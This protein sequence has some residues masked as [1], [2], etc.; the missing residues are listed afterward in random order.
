[1]VTALS[2][3]EDVVDVGTFTDGFY[4]VRTDGD[5]VQFGPGAEFE[6]PDVAISDIEHA[7]D[8]GHWIG[9]WNVGAAHIAVDG[10]I[11]I[12]DRTRLGLEGNVH[13]LLP[14]ADA[15]WVATGFGLARVD[16]D[17]G[18]SE[19]ISLVPEFPNTAVQ[20]LAVGA[21]RIWA[22]TTRGLVAIDEDTGALTR[23]RTSDGLAVDE[24][25]ARSGAEGAD[26]RV[27]FGGLG[28]LVSF[29]PEE[30]QLASRP[31]RTAFTGAWVDDESVLLTDP[32][33]V[34]PEASS[35]RL[36]FLAADHHNAEANRFRWRLAGRD[37]DWGPV[38]AEPFAQLTG[39]APGDYRFE[40]QA[41]N[42]NGLWNLEPR[43]I[44]VHV[45]P[46]WWQT[47]WGQLLALVLAAGLV[48][49]WSRLQTRWIRQRNRALQAEVARQ[50]EALKRANDAK[51]AF[52]ANMS[53][54]IRTPMN[55]IMG[56]TRLALSTELSEVQRDYLQ[57]SRA[58][59][60]SLLEII[61]DVLD[62][63]KIEAG[64]LELER[65]RFRLDDVLQRLAAIFSMQAGEKG[66]ELVFS[67]A[68]GVAQEMEG[69]PYRLNQVLVN[70]LGNAIKFTQAGEVVLE[71]A[72]EPAPSG[73]TCLRFAVRD[74]GIGMSERERKRLFP[75]FTQADESTTRRFGGTGLGLTITRQL[76][77][78]MDGE[79]EVESTPGEGTT[80]R[81]TA[82]FGAVAPAP[83][84]MPETIRGRRVLVADDNAAARSVLGEMLARFGLEVA[85]AGDA[86]AVRDALAD[87][88]IALVLMDGKLNDGDPRALLG[89][90]APPVFLIGTS[91][92]RER[93]EALA[94]AQDAASRPRGVLTKPL[95]ASTLLDAVLDIVDPDLRER[96]P[97]PRRG[98]VE[99]ALSGL[100]V[101][102]A[103]DHPVNR[104]I[105]EEL[106]QQAGVD[107]LSVEI[108]AAAVEILRADARFDAVLMG[109]QMPVMDGLEATR[110]VREELGLSVPIVA[111][112]AHAFQEARER[113]RDAGMDDHVAKPVD[114][115]RLYLVLARVTDRSLQ[116]AI[117]LPD[118]A[119]DEDAPAPLLDRALG[120][121]RVGGD[122]ALLARLLATFVKELPERRSRLRRARSVEDSIALRD[123]AHGMKGVAGNL[124]AGAL[125]RASSALEEAADGAVAHWDAAIDEVEE[126]CE[127]L[128]AEVERAAELVEV[129]PESAPTLG[130]TDLEAALLRLEQGVE[131]CDPGI[132]AEL[133]VP[134]VAAALVALDAR[135]ASELER[136]LEAMEFAAASTALSALRAA[137]G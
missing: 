122:A 119:P 105:A 97:A 50:T 68:P 54:E 85:F 82:T 130:P 46:A 83:F 27:Y 47:L 116:G 115:D 96:V 84:Q 70:L 6:L 121:R 43:A 66:L 62:L 78:Y 73:A 52:L 42:T 89:E 127:A 63:S 58:A 65:V 51:S 128:T 126:A 30:V 80:V 81:F 74:T 24:F 125:A 26:G 11:E 120:I 86:D 104:Q 4:R 124:A 106:L 23:F 67:V 107:V 13:D 34:P 38:Q 91:Y 77:E 55:A 102:L 18:E 95:N 53:H 87:G 61:D 7:A 69:D 32:L 94:G 132:D 134:G 36:R 10:T 137:K 72:V 48:V 37:E 135:T 93:L 19:R 111:M 99:S 108:G 40:V 90:Q 131:R 20:R 60:D 21:G 98:A 113:S 33:V 112:T 5:W 79:I 14:L 57:K 39:L 9:L 2:S 76:I 12:Y 35:L 59:S 22:A 92:D 28:G 71:V 109:I 136:A 15:L 45:L 1:M 101:L 110:L 114:P 3:H 31:P 133:R 103:E 44:G 41:A 75:P 16:L 118:E 100:R 25:F 8:G 49:A 29:R 129:E 17:T 88:E 64:H 56:M 123:T 117:D